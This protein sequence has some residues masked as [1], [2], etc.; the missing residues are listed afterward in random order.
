MSMSVTQVRLP[1]GLS[2][3]IDTLVEK[4]LY[5]T[6][7]DVVRDAV[8]KLI[9]EKHVGSI[10]NKRNSVKEIRALRKQLS[11]EKFDINAINHSDE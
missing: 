2:K 6:K 4:G 8:R 1:D 10:P 7:S 3:E 5:S 9:L 11:R